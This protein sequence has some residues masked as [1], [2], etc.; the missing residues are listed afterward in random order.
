MTTIIHFLKHSLEEL[1]LNVLR[2]YGFDVSLEKL[3]ELK[4]MSKLKYLICSHELTDDEIKTL[5]KNLPQVKEI[6]TMSDLKIAQSEERFWQTSDVKE[7]K[8]FKANWDMLE[9]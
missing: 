9:K 5:K 1:D 3:M 6:K 4:S 2:Q 7:L 8:V